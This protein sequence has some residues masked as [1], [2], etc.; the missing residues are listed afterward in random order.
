MYNKIKSHVCW[1]LGM[2]QGLSTVVYRHHACQSSP[3]QD[4]LEGTLVT[5]CLHPHLGLGWHS[6]PHGR[7]VSFAPIG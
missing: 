6:H 3:S 2:G 4:I 1:F 5:F 7:F